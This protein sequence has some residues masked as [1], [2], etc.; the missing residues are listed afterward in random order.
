MGFILFFSLFFFFLLLSSIL[1]G[2][3]GSI[4]CLSEI[5]TTLTSNILSLVVLG[6]R[7]S[8]EEG[9]NGSHKLSSALNLIAGQ[10]NIGDY[11][12]CLGWIN[13]INGMEKKVNRVAKEVDE[14]LEG[15]IE[16]GLKKQETNEV[17]VNGE[18]QQNFLD[19]LLQLQREENAN[20]HRDSIKAILLNMMLAGA[21]TTY[22]LMEWTFSQLMRNPNVMAKLQGEVRQKPGRKL[23]QM[24]T[25]DD[26]D[27]LPYL[28]AVIRETLR[29]NPPV[30]L[31][32]RVS[33]EAVKIMEYDVAAGS[34]VFINV[35]V[36]GRDPLLWEEADVFRPERFLNSPV[37]VK[38]QHFEYLPFGSG[39]RI[40]PGS[41]LALTTA[42]LT[43][44]NLIHNFN[45]ALPNNAKPDELDMSEGHGMVTKRKI[46]LVLV[47][48]LPSS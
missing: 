10:V 4:I 19:V 23:G 5:V 27:S 48:S 34:E 12:P 30:T 36:I 14:Y 20:L 33:K 39:R 7:H 16:Q 1:A 22:S 11:I 41:S 32:N 44:A 29:T 42:Q 47:A 24:I 15:I 37:D 28:K 31:L 18:G 2:T 26:L 13:H 8:G 21:E 25:E 35:K 38:G 9:N 43:L 6:K 45:F 40:C 17:D 46:P 3:T